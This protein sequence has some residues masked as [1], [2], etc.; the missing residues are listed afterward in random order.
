MRD[1]LQIMRDL[2]PWVAPILT[3][4]GWCV[5]VVI[6]RSG[7]RN[8]RI[9]AEQN[10]ARSWEKDNYEHLRKNIADIK[11]AAIEYYSKTGRD[12]YAL[13]ELIDMTAIFAKHHNYLSN[14]MVGFASAWMSFKK[15][16]TERLVDEKDRI[17]ARD[18]ELIKKI[19]TSYK[20]LYTELLSEYQKRIEQIR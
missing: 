20:Q 7:W 16:V 12:H 2:L 9:V 13:M 1:L 14:S 19:D 17:H 4:I 8:A 18:S 11:I 15:A 6:N 3:V 10:F 5:V